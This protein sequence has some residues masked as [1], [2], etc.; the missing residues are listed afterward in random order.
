MIDAWGKGR[1]NK[2]AGCQGRGYRVWNGM[3]HDGNSVILLPREQ[4]RTR[5][6]GR[7]GAG[8]KAFG[9]VGGGAVVKDWG[10][11]GMRV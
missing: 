11:P 3:F 1:G 5:E 7:K 8:G 4:V 10:M 2:L 6:M 9:E